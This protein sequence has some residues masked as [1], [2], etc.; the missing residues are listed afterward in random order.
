MLYYEKNTNKYSQIN[1]TLPY[2]CIASVMSKH[3]ANEVILQCND[4]FEER[5]PK[6]NIYDTLLDKI[7][8]SGICIVAYNQKLLGYAALYVND[9]KSRTEYITFFAVLPEYQRKYIGKKI[10]DTC[11]DI[12]LER[13]MASENG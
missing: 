13:G 6:K 10:M 9:L 11:L 1:N 4:A 5:T 7:N 2:Y 8:I 3:E 12:V